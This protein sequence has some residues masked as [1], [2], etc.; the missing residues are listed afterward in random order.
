MTCQIIL[1]NLDDIHNFDT[2]YSWHDCT[3]SQL[4][5]S[6]CQ[7]ST[8]TFPGLTDS[9][10]IA[11]LRAC[12]ASSCVTSMRL[13]PSHTR[14][15]SPTFRPPEAVKIGTNGE[16]KLL[17][18]L[19]NSQMFITP[20]TSHYNHAMLYIRRECIEATQLCMYQNQLQRYCIL[21]L[22]YLSAAPPSRIREMSTCP[23]RG[24]SIPPRMASLIGPSCM[25]EYVLI[26]NYH[27]VWKT[28]IYFRCKAWNV[29]WSTKQI[30]KYFLAPQVLFQNG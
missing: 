30:A 19:V 29:F 24:V 21:Q 13:T 5:T 18:I 11:R 10:S 2:L 25:C 26:I 7:F 20:Q 22:P 3:V 28:V 27:S 12:A 23:P 14:I 4:W 15:W 17:Q 8:T 1:H 6:D 9:M 16:K